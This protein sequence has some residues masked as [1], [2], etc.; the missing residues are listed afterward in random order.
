MKRYKQLSGMGAF[1]VVWVGQAVSLL[2]TS[3]TAFAL[4]IW[5]FERTGS[6]TALALVGFFFIT[7]LLI[8]SPVAGAIVDRSN[9]KLMMMISDLASGIVTIVIFYLY[10]INRLEVWHLYIGAAFSGTFQTFQWPAYSAA[11]TLI[12]PKK[13]YARAHAMSDLAGNSSNIF[14]P[15]SAGA[16]L[17]IIGLQGIFFIDIISFIFAIGTLLFVKIPQPK[18]T[19]EGKK[20]QGNIWKESAYGFRY[21][22]ERRSLLG[23]QLIFLAGNFFATFATTLY[24]PMILARTESNPLIFGSVQTAGAVGGVIGGLAI[25][26]WG[27]PSR[28][29]KGVLYGWILSAVLGLIIVGLGRSFPI[30]AA[31][32]FFGAFF[33]PLVNS[34]NQAIWQSKVAPDVQGRVFAIRRLIAWFVNPLATLMVGPLADFIME[35]ALQ[36]G[37]SLTG[38]LGRLVGVG[39][40]SGMSVIIIF[41]G[42]CVVFVVLAGFSFR[43]IRDVEDIL[44]DHKA[45][46]EDET[47]HDEAAQNLNKLE[48]TDQDDLQRSI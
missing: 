39:P 2:G 7:P 10:I 12:V 15:L 31:G 4:T 35:P 6:A 17:A 21:I 38:S 25:S 22:F 20:G 37:G 13:H 47:P 32:F 34:S 9:R 42:L 33:I 44:P 5:A 48:E 16:L 30:W 26:A 41:S 3:M 23:L 43:E 29:A 36:P 11:I 46:T 14:A 28:R 1:T 27:G 24:A 18:A 45:E 8:V 40:G 19:E